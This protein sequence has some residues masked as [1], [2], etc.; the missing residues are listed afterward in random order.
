MTQPRTVL[1]AALAVASAL[2]CGG[3]Q[4]PPPPQVAAPEPPVIPPEAAPATEAVEEEFGYEDPVNF[5]HFTAAT[6]G[7]KVEFAVLAAGTV[8]VKY[9]VAEL[10][11]GCADVIVETDS[12]GQGLAFVDGAASHPIVL[13]RD[14]AGSL[15]TLPDG[16][17][18]EGAV[19]DGA[20]LVAL[21]EPEVAL[22]E[23]AGEE[24]T[25]YRATVDGKEY[26]AESQLGLVQT[27]ATHRAPS[28]VRD[29]FELLALGEGTGPPF[30]RNFGA[31]AQALT[32]SRTL[33]V[34]DRGGFGTFYEPV[35]AAADASGA[36]AALAEDPPPT[37][38]WIWGSPTQSLEGQTATG[39]VTVFV[40]QEAGW[41]QAV[42]ADSTSPAISPPFL[43]GKKGMILSMSDK[44]AASHARVIWS[45]DF[46]P[47]PWPED[48]KPPPA[49]KGLG[50]EA[51]V[52]PSADPVA[53]STGQEPPLVPGT[54]PAIPPTGA[55]PAPPP[56]AG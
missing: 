19:F 33:T 16:A 20:A 38:G 31:A 4:A 54:A 15:I 11:F 2:A 5:L 3:G 8:A 56:G 25:T 24:S 30:C 52:A 18:A 41:S 34:G 35:D 6:A 44:D 55:P 32:E 1:I 53:P 37:R 36:L 28:W 47:R 10:P 27:C 17:R 21:S 40:R 23:E 42:V 22:R 48:L 51:P 13:S 45:T 46:C 39:P 26:E 14:G 9:V 7:C 29:S 49:W 12:T 43:C 50:P